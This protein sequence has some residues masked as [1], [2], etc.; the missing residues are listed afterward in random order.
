MNLNG[1]TAIITG[2]ASG[3]GAALARRMAGMGAQVMIAD[4]ADAK[5][6]AGEIGG[7]STVC[8]VTSE[9]DIQRVVA[10]TET[11]FGP[12]DIFVSNAGLG[13]GDPSHAASAPNEDWALNWNVHVMSHVYAARAVLPAMIERGDGYLVNMASAAGLLN[14]IGDAAYSA[15]K[16]AAVGFAEALAITHRGDG[17]KVSVVCPQYVATPLIGLKDADADGSTS[18]LSTDQAAEAI[19]QGMIDERFL[20]LTHP[21]VRQ[22]VQMK[23][24]DH[25]QWIAGMRK[26]R[27]KAIRDLGGIKP[28]EFHKIV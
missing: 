3:I 10:E 25:D 28:Q 27:A 22:F 6:L 20:I 13:R 23:A 24:A 26:L 4:R 19:V 5:S 16:H 2:A 8:D 12:V 7:A 18:L 9:A 21:Q 11:R 1:K 14:Q 17:V 15:T